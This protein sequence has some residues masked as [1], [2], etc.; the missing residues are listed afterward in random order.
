MTWSFWTTI[1]WVVH[2]PG[3]KWISS[4]KFFR[5]I[6]QTSHHPIKWNHPTVWSPHSKLGNVTPM[7]Q[8]HPWRTHH[9]QPSGKW[10]RRGNMWGQCS[11]FWCLHHSHHIASGQ[12]IDWLKRH[13]ENVMVRWFKQLQCTRFRYLCNGR[14]I[15]VPFKFPC[16]SQGFNTLMLKHVKT[17]SC[18]WLVRVVT[19]NITWEIFK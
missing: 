2:L 14:F 12:L 16:S 1:I 19:S 11:W 8:S 10:S 13:F 17:S 9:P 4:Y 15:A 7:Q 3:N 5:E 6:L 18:L